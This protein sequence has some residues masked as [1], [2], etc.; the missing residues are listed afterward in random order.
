MALLAFSVLSL[1]AC[2]TGGGP[3]PDEPSADGWPDVVSCVADKIPS[4]IDQI[5]EALL[6]GNDPTDAL[7]DLAEVHGF[8]VVACGVSKLVDDWT[9]PGATQSP[10]RMGAVGRGRGFLQ[11]EGIDVQ[12]VGG[13]QSALDLPSEEA[14]RDFMRRLYA[15]MDVM[16]TMTPVDLTG[17]VLDHHSRFLAWPIFE[18]RNMML[19]PICFVDHGLSL[20]ELIDQPPSFDDKTV[21]EAYPWA[22]RASR[23]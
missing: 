6:A 19:V 21:G 9:S 11:R 8:D 1:V 23:S 12:T 4:A 7:T 2:N 3:G 5:T 18:P 17:D 15:R 10:A 13:E 20:E 16:E 22:P 14:T